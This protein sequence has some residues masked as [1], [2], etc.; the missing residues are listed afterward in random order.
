MILPG[1]EGVSYQEPSQTATLLTQ[2]ARNQVAQ[3][4]ALQAI[5]QVLEMQ[6]RVQVGADTK[7]V[8][9]LKYLE[10]EKSAATQAVLAEQAASGA[11]VDD[12]GVRSDEF[13]EE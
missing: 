5:L 6:F 4:Q 8:W 3:Q 13:V 9:K 7:A 11:D 1:Q 12:V 2:I 10:S